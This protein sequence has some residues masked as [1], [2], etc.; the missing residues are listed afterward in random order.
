MV[1]VT[2]ATAPRD[3]HAD[4]RSAIAVTI[5]PAVSAPPLPHFNA[6]THAHVR[7]DADVSSSTND[8]TF[9]ATA[10]DDS[11]FTAAAALDGWTAAA[12]GLDGW[13]ATAGLDGW[14]AAAP[15]LDGR[16][17]T[18][19]TTTLR[20]GTAAARS[21]VFVFALALAL[22]APGV[23]RRPALRQHDAGIGPLA[24]TGRR[25]RR[26]RCRRRQRRQRQNQQA[27]AG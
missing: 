19:L 15:A 6:G 14:A 9:A 4:A 18:A 2:P 7:A 16:T 21:L 8:R 13:A 10:L 27:R 12:T 1:P 3:V 11:T 5:A 25:G 20:S 17:A 24:R 26:S 23:G 22:A